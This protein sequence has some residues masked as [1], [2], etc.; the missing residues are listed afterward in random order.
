MLLAAQRFLGI[1]LRSWRTKYG[2]ITVSAQAFCLDIYEF[3]WA[4]CL[5]AFHR[6][7]WSARHEIVRSIYTPFTYSTAEPEGRCR[8]DRPRCGTIIK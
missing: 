2:D 5:V 3:S 8:E 4:S 6:F 7:E 1:H